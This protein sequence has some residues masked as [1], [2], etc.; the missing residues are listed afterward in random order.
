MA[1]YLITGGAGFIGSNIAR[2]LVEDG[3]HVR[4]ID[5]LSSGKLANL[6]VIRKDI[7]LIRGDIRDRSAVR[8]A[9]K[10]MDH[11]L[12]HAALPSVKGSIDDPA[13][14]SDVNINGTLQVLT[15]A[16]DAGVKRVVFASSC[17][18]YGNAAKL[19][20]KED[21]R[22]DP[23]SPY[24]ASK[25]AG[26][27]LCRVFTT[28]YGLETVAL[29]YFNVFGPGQDPNCEY[30]AAIPRF[31]ETVSRGER[32]VIYGDG[33][34][35][36]DFV[37]VNNVVA[38][39]ILAATSRNRGIVGGTFNIATGKSLSVNELLGMILDIL[40]ADVRPVNRAGRPG[41]IRRSAADISLAGK[42]LG[43]RPKVGLEKGLRALISSM[44]E[45]R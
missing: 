35:T 37:S 10:G 43:Y 5:D 15:A 14:T 23:L 25:A 7:D 16:R 27:F 11:V 22:L 34:Q 2:K 29:R 18:V 44:K 19:P 32:P 4:V 36:R 28:V 38:A 12:H 20:I 39:N 1:K 41:D 13:G 42:L 31:I 17:A 3:H 8:K 30:S 26:E 40:G 45:E 9:C 21:A 33:R 6:D 24:A